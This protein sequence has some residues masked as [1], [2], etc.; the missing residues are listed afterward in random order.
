MIA[1]I[2]DGGVYATPGRLDAVTGQ[3]AWAGDRS[4]NCLSFIVAYNPTSAP[5]QTKTQVGAYTKNVLTPGADISTFFGNSPKLVAH[6]IL[7]NYLKLSNRMDLFDI[8]VPDNVFP[9]A[10]LSSIIGFG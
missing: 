8:V 10:M 7:A 4:V 6:V 3:L 1:G 2:T 5:V 9:K